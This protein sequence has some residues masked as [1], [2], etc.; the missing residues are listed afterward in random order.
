MLDFNDK[1]FD[2]KVKNFDVDTLFYTVVSCRYKKKRSGGTKVEV[3]KKTFGNKFCWELSLMTGSFKLLIFKAG[4]S[5]S[6]YINIC[7]ITVYF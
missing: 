2:V 4:L 1:N 6:V 7:C 3:L 5:H